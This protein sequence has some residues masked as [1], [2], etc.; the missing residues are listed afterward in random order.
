MNGNRLVFEGL[1]GIREEQHHHLL[2]HMTEFRHLLYQHLSRNYENFNSG[3]AALDAELETLPE[4]IQALEAEQ[5]RIAEQLADPALYQSPSQD[6]AALSARGEA[7]EA[8]LL[9]AL[10]RWEA[11]EAKA[12]GYAAAWPR[13]AGPR[14]T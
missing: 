5:A 11:L 2:T 6:A 1:N 14:F 12:A 4:H 8:E 10:S 3:G 9:A 7:I 13:S